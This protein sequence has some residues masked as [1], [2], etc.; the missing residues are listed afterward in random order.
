MN[1]NLIFLYRDNFKIY[2][3][4]FKK[5]L[6]K[7]VI[8]FILCGYLDEETL[9]ELKHVCKVFS[10]LM[11]KSIETDYKV[12]KIQLER[13]RIKKVININFINSSI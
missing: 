2:N 13:I 8:F 3:K 1:T 6:K 10:E 11:K 4:K 9:Y 7:P 5:I 12:L